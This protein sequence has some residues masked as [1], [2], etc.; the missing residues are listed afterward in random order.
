MRAFIVVFIGLRGSLGAACKPITF[1]MNILVVNSIML[2]K[3]GV[4]D[5]AHV[6]KCVTNANGNCLPFK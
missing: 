3:Y 5:V 4:Q 1:T 6:Y 2:G